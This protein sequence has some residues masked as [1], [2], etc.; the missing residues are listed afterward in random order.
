M[1]KDYYEMRERPYF[2]TS[3]AEALEIAGASEGNPEN[4]IPL[5]LPPT[6]WRI[7]LFLQL[8]FWWFAGLSQQ[9]LWSGI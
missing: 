3:D 6:S 2:A 8:S 7:L 1:F 9:I 5:S 4:C